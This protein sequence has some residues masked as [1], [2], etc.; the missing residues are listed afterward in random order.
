MADFTLRGDGKS[1]SIDSWIE[2][3]TTFDR[4]GAALSCKRKRFG[5]HLD[6]GPPIQQ[7]LIAC[8]A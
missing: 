8:V 3:G 2:L 7:T 5:P 6:A 4:L 1:F